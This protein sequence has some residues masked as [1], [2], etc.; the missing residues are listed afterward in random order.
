MKFIIIIFFLPIVNLF[1]IKSFNFASIFFLMRGFSAFQNR[2]KIINLWFLLSYLFYFPELITGPHRNISEWKLPKLD[3][4]KFSI[5]NFVKIFFYLNIILLTGIL[6]NF[7]EIEEG[8]IFFKAL[9]THLCLYFQF[10]SACNIVNIINNIFGES[11]IK[12][13]NNPL[14]SES[15]GDFWNRWHIS[16]GNFT[17]NYISQPLTFILRKKGFRNKYAFAISTIISFIFIGIWHKLSFNYLYFGIYF[18]FFILFER[19]ELFLKIKTLIPKTIYRAASII[20]T[21]FIIVIGYIFVSDYLKNVI[22][23]P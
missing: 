15:I 21:Q 9:V 8:S 13:F 12:N 3:L 4:S 11:K 23:H 2:K 20:Y 16:L 17:K 5:N 10:M 1:L 22:I 14:L 19:T 18:A 6:Y 7:L